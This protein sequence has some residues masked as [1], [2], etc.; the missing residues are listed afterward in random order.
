ML[1]K[2]EFPPNIKEIKKY[3]NL[4]ENVV[5][6]YRNILYNPSGVL[7]DDFLHCHEFIHSQQQ[8]DDPDDWWNK[9][10]T[11]KHFRLDQEL[12]AYRAQYQKVKLKINDRNGLHKYLF[13]LAADLSSEMYG[14]LI[15]F[16]VAMEKIKQ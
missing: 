9:Y 13:N 16:S 14:N 6:T 12:E 3:F 5:F 2:N 4:P 15:S 1:I 7:I 10:F 8:G 11:D